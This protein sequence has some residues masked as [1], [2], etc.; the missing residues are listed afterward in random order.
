MGIFKKPEN[1]LKLINKYTPNPFSP[2]KLISPSFG[3]CSKNT[4]IS[5]S[6]RG[7]PRKPMWRS[8]VLSTEA[9]QV[10]QSLKLAKATACKVEQVINNKLSR[11][12]KADLMDTLTELKRQNEWE[13]AHKVFDYIRKEIWYKPDLSL[14]CDMIFIFGKNK[15]VDN[16]ENVFEE[17]KKE[18]LVPDTRT[19]AEMIGVFLKVGMVEKAMEMYTLMKESS[20]VPDKLTLTILIRNL[21]K[22]GEEELAS[23]VKKDC[24]EYVDYPEKFIE[25][26]AYNNKGNSG[27]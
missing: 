19:Y 20:C 22:V 18:G 14:Y 15:M 7:G 9:I 5:S 10:V 13:L 25:E 4:K 21:E 24:I 8:R 16:A 27:S 17:L 3:F 12:L 6:L 11:L 1:N 26:E 23:I 2:L